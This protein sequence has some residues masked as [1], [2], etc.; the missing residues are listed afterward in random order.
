[1]YTSIQ[2]TDRFQ[3]VAPCRPDLALW[4]ARGRHLLTKMDFD[5]VRCAVQTSPALNA[6]SA[7][8]QVFVAGEHPPRLAERRPRPRPPW[9]SSA[10]LVTAVCSMG[11]PSRRSKGNT[12]AWLVRSHRSG[13]GSESVPE[14]Q[15]QA[16]R[17]TAS[18]LKAPTTWVEETDSC[19]SQPEIQTESGKH[20]ETATKRS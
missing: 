9:A 5:F 13:S 12:E 3:R 8:P 2:I 15:V 4:T 18:A 20:S 1:M 16:R 17:A 6:H 10:T 14:P 19:L 7:R 11:P